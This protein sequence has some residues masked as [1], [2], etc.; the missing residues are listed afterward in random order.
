MRPLPPR[1]A[2]ILLALLGCAQ[3]VV[4]PKD[5][6]PA[7]TA[8]P[9]TGRPETGQPA[10]TGGGSG[11]SGGSDETAGGDSHSPETAQETGT[12]E[13]ADS[14]DTGGALP[15]WSSPCTTYADPYNTGVVAD[16]ALDELS[17]IAVSRRDPDILWVE[18]D[19]GGFAE[20]YAL[21]TVGDT[22]V[23]VALD[24]ATNADWE[25]IAVGPCGDESCVYIGEIGNND[26]DRT[27]MGVYVLPEPDLSTA[28]DGLITST[29]W[30]YYSFDYPDVD[31][32]AEALAVTADGLPVVLTKHYEGEDSTVYV[33]PSLDPLAPVTLTAVGTVVTGPDGTGGAAALT[34]ADLWIDDSR[35]IFRTYGAIYEVDLSGGLAAITDAPSTLTP[36]AAELHGEAVAYDPW[37]GGFWQ[38]AEGLNPMLWYTGCAS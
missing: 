19:H 26:L 12:G 24:G 28:V 5:S 23:T 8:A 31:E 10:E 29:D 38:V 20:I 7:E 33:F 25:D 1:S 22:V 18:E 6:P 16:S 21:D 34:A 37:R 2:A 36:G 4:Q 27:D 9:E 32:N 30:T 35:L 3:P 17:G 14:G 11:G 13:T 15:G